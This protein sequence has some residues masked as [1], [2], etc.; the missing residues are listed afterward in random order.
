MFCVV[1]TVENKEIFYS[2]VPKSWVKGTYLSWPPPGVKEKLYKD[3]NSVPGDDWHKY[4]ISEIEFVDTFKEA[5]K[6][7]SQLTGCTTENEAEIWLANKKPASKLNFNKLITSV[8]AEHELLAIA[9]QSA[10]SQPAISEPGSFERAISEPGSFRPASSKPANFLSASTQSSTIQAAST[11]H[12]TIQDAS[13]QHSTIQDASTQHSTIQ[14]ASTQHSTIQFATSLSTTPRTIS[15]SSVDHRLEELEKR[16]IIQGIKID[17][18]L[19]IVEDL[20]RQRSNTREN[21]SDLEEESLQVELPIKTTPCLND[22]NEKLGRKDFSRKFFNHLKARVSKHL[23]ITATNLALKLI[24]EI[25]DPELLKLYSWSGHGKPDKKISF[26]ELQNL[27]KVF[28][29]LLSII[30]SNH[31]VRETERI[32]QQHILKHANARARAHTSRASKKMKT[33]S[34]ALNLPNMTEDNLDTTD[35]SS[36]DDDFQ[37]HGAHKYKR[38]VK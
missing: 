28:S 17:K 3:P 34:A 23:K 35:A 4:K 30:D 19:D 16:Q 5:K 32:L 6:L 31:T 37:R 1:K 12:S 11:Q 36:S 29:K 9:S 26:R 7:A 8:N 2:A 25:I 15:R 10:S 18:I 33:G 20:Q 27:I 14:A 22:L 38:P 13:T 21:D 24:D